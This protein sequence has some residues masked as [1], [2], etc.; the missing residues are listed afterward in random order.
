MYRV[1]KL[2]VLTGVFFSLILLA[3]GIRIANNLDRYTSQYPDP[4]ILDAQCRNRVPLIYPR[5][6]YRTSVAEEQSLAGIK[7][8]RHFDTRE[9]IIIQQVPINP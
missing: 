5:P 6:I 7:T 8:V 9:D 1:L 3:Y 2:F 4:I